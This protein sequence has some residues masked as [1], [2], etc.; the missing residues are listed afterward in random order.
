MKASEFIKRLQ[1]LTG[2][3]G[4]VE[5]VTHWQGDSVL[6]ESAEASIE[7]C[8]WYEDSGMLTTLGDK[9]VINVY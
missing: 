1:E 4:D 9:Q 2:E 6:I 3:C 8:N 7:K 5:V